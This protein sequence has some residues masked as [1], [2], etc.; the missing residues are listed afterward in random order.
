MNSKQHKGCVRRGLSA[1][2]NDGLLSRH[3]FTFFELMVTIVILSVGIVIIYQGFL[4]GLFYQKH[5]ICRAYAMNLLEHKMETVQYLLQHGEEIPGYKDGESEN[6]VLNN[7]NVAFHCSMD[8]QPLRDLSNIYK[9]DMKLT[10]KERDREFKL[11]RVAYVS[12]F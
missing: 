11:S 7:Q 1:G 12:K 10:W 9:V 3:G 4:T 6:L 5:L 8:Y 2:R